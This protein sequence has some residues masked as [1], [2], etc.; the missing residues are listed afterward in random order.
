M[1]TIRP[2]FRWLLGGISLIIG[3]ILLYVPASFHKLG[4]YS[5]IGVCFLT[6]L[7]CFSHGRLIDIL[8]GLKAGDSYGA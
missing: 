2:V 3:L 8:P 4:F 1:E 6:T 7:A 5:V